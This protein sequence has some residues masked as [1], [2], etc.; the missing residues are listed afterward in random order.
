MLLRLDRCVV[1]LGTLLLFVDG[2][3]AQQP[4]KAAGKPGVSLNDAKAFKGYTLIAPMNST[5][6]HLIDMEGRVVHTWECKDTPALSTYL[7]DNGN[8]LRP[9][10]MGKGGPGA[11]GK[12]QEWSWDG[13][14]RWDYKFEG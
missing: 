1:I 2:L 9:A 4:P 10:A 5:K 14:L 3:R 8:L 13:Q 7:L 6:A 11:G 12:V